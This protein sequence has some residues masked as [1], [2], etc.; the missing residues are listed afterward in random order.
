[1]QREKYG[2]VYIW[3]DRKRNLYYVGSHWGHENDGY[4][5]SSNWMRHTYKRRPED[6]KRRI[7]SKIY[8]NQKD[9]LKEEFRYLS[10]IKPEEI[11]VRY[12]NLKLDA[13][14]GK[15]GTK[16]GHHTEET[17][18]KMRA[19][20]L[21]KTVTQATRDKIAKT[22]DGRKLSEEHL[23]ALR[24]G[25]KHK[26]RDYSD[27]VFIEKMRHAAKNRS[28]ETRKKISENNKRLQAEGKIG[29]GG[30]KHSEATKNKMRVS[31][32]AR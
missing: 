24:H 21:G 6:F 15:F 4:V 13:S 7:I 3:R 26:K 8:T 29:M 5:C 27:S 20:H 16:W 23:A 14:A 22:L 25:A 11:R 18:L 9:L 12:Y 10:M 1:M 32:L 31:A 17:K 30:K 19:A 28:A 2:F